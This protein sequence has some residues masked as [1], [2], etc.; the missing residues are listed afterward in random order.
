MKGFGGK[1]ERMRPLARPR[2]R[3]WNNFKVDLKVIGWVGV[4]SIQS[5]RFW[6]SGW[7]L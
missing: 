2:H 4:E 6:T 7:L 3:W 1:H 5:L